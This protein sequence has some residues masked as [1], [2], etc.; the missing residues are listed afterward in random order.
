MKKIFKYILI[1][2]LSLGLVSC[3]KFFDSMEGDLSKVTAEDLLGS[4]N[5]LLALLANLYSSLPDM[6]MSSSDQST[7]FANGS[8]S[9]PNYASTVSGKWN[10]GDIR[11]VNNFMTAVEATAEEG[12]ISEDTKKAYL[13]EALFV[14]ACIYFA[15]VRT[16]G[17]IPIVEKSLDN[18][19]DGEEN[20]GLYYPRKTEKESWDWVISQ[21]QDAADMLPET[22][23][24][25]M[26]IT[27]YGALAMKAR[28]ALWAAS[29]SKYW[30]RAPLNTGYIAY[31]KKLTYMEASYADEYYAQAIDAAEKVIK[32]GKY[33]LVG[34]DPSSIAA[35]KQ[36]FIDLFQ[37][38]NPTEG[39]IGRSYKTGSTDNGNGSQAWPAHQVVTGYQTGTYSVTLNLA[40][41]YDYYSDATNRTRAG[42]KI[43]TLEN[44]NEDEYFTEPQQQMTAAM[45]ANYKHYDS[46]DG[47]FKLKDARFQ[48]WVAYPGTT[49]RGKVI[50][51]EGGMVMPDGSVNVY[52]NDNN[53]VNF[54]GTNYYPYGGVGGD[55]SFFYQLNVDTNGSNRSFYCFTIRKGQEEGGYNA[56]PQTPWY[57]LRFSEMLLT[58]AEAVVESGKG[59]ASDAKKYLNDVRHR[60]G[61]KDDVDL[62]LENVLHEWKCEFAFENKWGD[63]LYRR[64]AYYN[65]NNTATVEEGSLGKKLTLIPMVDLSGDKAQWIFLRAV[66]YNT[67]PSKGYNGILEVRADEYYGSIPNHVYNRIEQNNTLTE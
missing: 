58:Y 45:V 56:N 25:E 9:T 37:D 26:R 27:K 55:V 67:Q 59:N 35:A 3:D 54:K 32:S 42:R 60:A 50:N 63:V 20:L 15:N 30:S 6:S 49:F 31:Q 10:Y 14:R 62:T 28:V 33:A 7:M 66:P 51:A 64:R 53:P 65:P 23:A 21:L 52:P 48:A 61:F 38:Y 11:A 5:G 36:N 2:G 47:P 57:N 40:D 18:E 41:E 24:Q 43:Q 1:A 8:R 46:V 16:H 22:Q 44:G 19:Y 17:G 4:D 34:Q 12:R 39:I 13:G 29:E